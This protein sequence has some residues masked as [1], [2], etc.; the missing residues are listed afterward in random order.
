MKIIIR[1]FILVFLL[2]AFVGCVSSKLPDEMPEDFSFSIYWGFD[3]EYDSNTKVLSNGFNYDLNIECKTELELSNEQ[4]QEVY[5]IIKKA[6]IDI[7]DEVIKTKHEIGIP[8]SDLKI[9][10]SYGNEKYTVTL[11]N[12]YLNDDMDKYIN[13][14][15]VG[16]AIK[17]IVEN[18]II[19][20]DEYKSL[21]ENQLLY[22]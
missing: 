13:G 6:K 19:S 16:K 8:S 5:E 21:P 20:S 18:Y 17:Q 9:T 22:D 3:G 7:F 14:K 11:L 4:L 10:I 12:S 15:Q 1:L 2:F